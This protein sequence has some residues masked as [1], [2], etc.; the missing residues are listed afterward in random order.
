MD[1]TGRI[2]GPE[3]KVEDFLSA[4]THLLRAVSPERCTVM[5]YRGES[6]PVIPTGSNDLEGSALLPGFS[7]T[8][9]EFLP[10]KHVWQDQPTR[11]SSREQ[12]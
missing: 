7:I 12:R 10:K 6:A 9:S 2:Y 4:D 3:E 5:I 1:E 11:R 8:A